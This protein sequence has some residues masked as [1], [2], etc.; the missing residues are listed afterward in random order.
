MKLKSSPERL[1]LTI[2]EAAKRLGIGR[3][4]AYEAARRGDIPTLQIG[5]R[6]LVPAAALER[7]L[8]GGADARTA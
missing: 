3:N 7:M 5:R 2:E 1:T 4:Q 8:N 6:W